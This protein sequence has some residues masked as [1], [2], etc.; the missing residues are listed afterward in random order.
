[1]E[2]RDTQALC[3]DLGTLRGMTRWESNIGQRTG[4]EAKWMDVKQKCCVLVLGC[5]LVA[6]RCQGPRIDNLKKLSVRDEDQP[7][8]HV[9]EGYTT[10]TFLL[11]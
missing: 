5:V 9:E 7:A 3:K 4:G 1:M 2:Y 10:E 6:E 8:E 11:S